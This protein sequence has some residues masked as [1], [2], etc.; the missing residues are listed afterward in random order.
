MP[1]CASPRGS[2]KAGLL[3]FTRHMTASRPWAG[4]PTPRAVAA[5]PLQQG[6]TRRLAAGAPR[7]VR[8]RRADGRALRCCCRLSWCFA[9]AAAPGAFW[10]AYIILYIILYYI[11]ILYYH[12]IIFRLLMIYNILYYL[13]FV[14]FIYANSPCSFVLYNIILYN[15]V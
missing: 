7:V 14:C 10:C 9:G 3:I 8:L 1:D 12:I 4:G 15:I 6:G 11:I 5:R 13:Y 2:S